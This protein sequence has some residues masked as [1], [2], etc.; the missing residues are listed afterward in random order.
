MLAGLPYVLW[1]V[2]SCF[3]LASRKKDDP[4]LHYHAIQGLIW[5]AVALALSLLGFLGMGLI[6]RLMPGSSTYLPGMIGMSFVV[7]GGLIAMVVFFTAIF[8]AWRATA[9]EMLRLPFIGDF[10]EQKMLDH[11][12]M[13]RRDF[14]K[15][16]EDSFIEP[17]PEEFDPIPFP[18]APVLNERAQE[19]LAQRAVQDTTPA[20]VK[21]AE[22]L[23][24]RQARQLQ[25][26]ADEARRKAEEAKRQAAL[27]QQQ[28]AADLRA[29][30]AA[31]VQ[32]AQ[33]QAPVPTPPAARQAPPVANAAPAPR[34]PAAPSSG[35]GD[36]ARAKSYPLI[37]SKVSNLVPPSPSPA[38]AQQRSPAQSSG[39]PAAPQNPAQ[40]KVKD[41]D[42]VRHYKERSKPE[43]SSDALKGWL[44]SVEKKP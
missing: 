23:A 39:H 12:G 9:G 15:H 14:I 19:I 4:Y 37:G 28:K 16:L 26:Q 6:F 10:A 18:T 36:A 8:L 38:A 29:Q 20:S 42:L 13:T 40:P 17:T 21:A 43:S 34:P 1:P 33:R 24:E 22:M 27:A 2:G 3:I 25:A 31:A 5:G 44:S 41:V 35:N 32:A 30:Q 11:T 7:G